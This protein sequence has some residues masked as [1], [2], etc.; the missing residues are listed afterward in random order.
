MTFSTRHRLALA[1]ASLALVVPVG[2]CSG[3]DN[4]EGDA[5]KLPGLTL[6]L[7][8]DS[9]GIEFD[10]GAAT[11]APRVINLWATWCAPCRAELPAFDDVA[12][13]QGDAID[14][15]GINVAED[16][17]RAAALVGELG[18]TFPQA[19][20]P[21]GDVTAELEIAGL[22]STIFAT[23]DGEIVEVHT[24]PLTEDSLTDKI[25]DLFG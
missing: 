12:A 13:A 16:M 6:T 19:I 22:P 8:D 15:L 11:A 20:D 4:S 5:R 25:D 3:G 21:A 18:L 9:G 14:M 7:I 23:A 1:F 2:A 17:E 10:L 24:G